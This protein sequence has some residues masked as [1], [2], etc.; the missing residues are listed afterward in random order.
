M[1]TIE[2][3]RADLFIELVGFLQ[4]KSNEQL[5][6]IAEEAGV[7]AQTLHNWAYGETFNPHLNTIIKV[8]KAM[9]YEIR[10][11]KKKTSLKRAA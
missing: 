2:K 8:S 9:G 4:R 11:S 6:Q 3:T 1:K 10:L 7:V 5:K